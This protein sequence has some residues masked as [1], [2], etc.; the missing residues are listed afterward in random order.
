MSLRRIVAVSARLRPL[1]AGAALL[2][3]SSESVRAA[4]PTVEAALAQVP[5]QKNVDYDR[6]TAAE[7]KTC[8]IAK[9]RDGS[10]NL[11]VVRGPSG[12]VLRAFADT[13]GDGTVDRFSYYKDGV[14]VYRDID[15]NHDKKVD[16]SR[17]LNS[18]GS[19]WGVDEDGNSAIDAWKVLSAEEASAEIVEAVKNRDAAAFARLLPTKDDL[20]AAG[21]EG[22]R[23]A[24]LVARVAAAPKAFAAVAG[25][26]KQLGADARWAS[27]LTP[28]PPGVLPAGMPGVTRDVMAY[29][30][31]VAIVDAK[32]GGSQVF[33]GSLV[34]CGDCWR[35]IDAPQLAG[36]TGE[37]GEAVGFFTPRSTGRTSGAAGPLD[38]E[39]LKP[40]FAKL[41]DVESKVAN[42][43]PAARKELATQQV[44]LMEEVLAAA[45]PTDRDFWIRQMAE[46]LAAYVQEGLLPD[47]LGRLEKIATTVADDQT[48]AAFVAFRLIQARHAVVSQQAGADVDKSEKARAG[49]LAELAAF[50]A[51][52]STSP[53]A[54][55]AML[56]LAIEDEFSAREQEALTRY[57][58]IVAKYPDSAPAR[59][60]KGA[61][62][63]LESVGKP[64]TL[65][66]TTLDGK[67]VAVESFRGVPVLVH[68][69]ATWCEPC[70]VDIAQIRELQAKYGPKKFV[71]VG[72][73]L[74]NDKAALAKFL[75]A[76]QLGWPQLHDAGGLD[77]RLA[78]ELG[79]LTLPTMLLLDAEGRV[80]DRN[81]VITE[82]EKKLEGLVGGK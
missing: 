34:R 65:A 5:T 60:A 61:A 35:P 47:G 80:V 17:W 19:R 23:L 49:W 58:E 30:N 79:V 39:R 28:Q 66:G 3:L 7:A 69:W 73:A 62:R 32:G 78:E 75:Q 51:K 37:R 6:P 67:P 29:D 4:G 2:C 31:V 15:A 82:L 43:P 53:D 25:G 77:G 18:A 10:I 81:L 16:Q 63:R 38:D 45:A 55:E 48:L 46:T 44:G 36:A 59:K 9:E 76:K 26:Q 13:N 1:A 70:K 40:L 42:A 8:T 52:H 68:Y 11:L 54:A 22:D 24:E 64:L 56:Q 20:Q 33:V 14:E 72:I 12:E 71:A 41:R 21:F 57:A 50:V 74:D 27:M